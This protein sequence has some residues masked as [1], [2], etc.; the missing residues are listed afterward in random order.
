MYGHVVRIALDGSDRT[1]VADN[2][3]GILKVAVDATSIYWTASDGV[4]C[5]AK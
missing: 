5:E 4:Y 3:K 1:V 2:P